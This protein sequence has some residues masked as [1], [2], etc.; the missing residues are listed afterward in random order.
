[1]PRLGPV[2]W[3]ELVRRLRGFGFEGP[4]TG[5][6]HPY[7]VRADVVITIPNPH[8]KEISVDLLVRLLSQAGIT[9]DE[10]TASK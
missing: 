6:R 10:W 2:S 1:M 7:M 5:G 4:F 8:R 9:R 3:Q